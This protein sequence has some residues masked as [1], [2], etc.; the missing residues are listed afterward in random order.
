MDIRM[1]PGILT[2]AVG[3]PVRRQAPAPAKPRRL[4]TCAPGK[5][6]LCG[7]VL[8]TKR[9]IAHQGVRRPNPDRLDEPRVA[10]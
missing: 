2:S 8:M 6:V 3:R 4:P 10:C 5:F 9:A 1:V 7:R